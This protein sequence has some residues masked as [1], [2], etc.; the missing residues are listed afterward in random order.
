MTLVTGNEVPGV[1]RQEFLDQ[2]R[3]FQA[4]IPSKRYMSLS[5]ASK[6]AAQSRSSA[7]ATSVSLVYRRAAIWETFHRLEDLNEPEE[8]PRFA[9]PNRYA[10]I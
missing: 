7:S 2:R 3:R 10:S 5:R 8:E 1:E 6:P 9:Q 4:R